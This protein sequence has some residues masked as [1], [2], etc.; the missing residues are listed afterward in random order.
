MYKNVIYL[1]TALCLSTPLASA[2]SLTGRPAGDERPTMIDGKKIA[3]CGTVD[4]EPARVVDV[5]R[6]GPSKRGFDII[7]DYSGSGFNA[8]QQAVFN[9]AIAM[10]EAVIEENGGS[11]VF[12]ITD[13]EF[14]WLGT[15]LAVA[16]NYTQNILGIPVSARIRVNNVYTWFVDPTPFDHS[17]Y[18]PIYNNPFRFDNG[19]GGAVHFDMLTTILHELGHCLGWTVGYWRFEDLVVPG[20]G[21]L[22]TFAPGS[23]QIT[24]VNEEDGTHADHATH[25]YDLMIPWIAQGERRLISYFTTMTAVQR[26]FEYH[27]PVTFLDA[28]FSGFPEL[29]T[30]ANPFNTYL[31]AV[32]FASPGDGLVIKGGNYPV[33]SPVE[34]T[35]PLVPWNVYGTVTIGQ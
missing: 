6:R 34:V 26:A 16:D 31:E 23:F 14:T 20:P 28:G 24:L 27:M 7:I 15:D 1:I 8:A 18:D 13:P 2:Q 5:K 33:A 4:E 25:P 21:N 35:K 32:T 22:R 17:E 11:G 29:G 30:V 19:Q 12:E 9:A 10:W 3:Y